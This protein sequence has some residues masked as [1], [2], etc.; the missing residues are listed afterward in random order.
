MEFLEQKTT[1][2]A[3]NLI[4][5]KDEVIVDSFRLSD[6][7]KQVELI[8]EQIAK[9]TSVRDEEVAELLNEKKLYEDKIVTYTKVVEEAGK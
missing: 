2:S 8:D 1:V 3:D 7:E 6:L 4:E 5:I 9:I